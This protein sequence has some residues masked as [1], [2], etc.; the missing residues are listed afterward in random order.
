M[1]SIYTLLDWKT[2]QKIWLIPAF[3]Q[4]QP[5]SVI[6]GKSG[7]IQSLSSVGVGRVLTVLASTSTPHYYKY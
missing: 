6:R 5:H 2:L 7:Q 4:S 1:T 3:N